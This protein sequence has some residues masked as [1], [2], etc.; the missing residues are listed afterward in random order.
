MNTEA[1]PYTLIGGEATVRA[2]VARFYQLM[3]ELPEAWEVRKLHPESLD[4]SAEK[5]YLYRN[6]SGPQLNV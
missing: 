1:T 3:D 2:L 4:G 6:C 5:L